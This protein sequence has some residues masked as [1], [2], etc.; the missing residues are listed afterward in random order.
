[1]ADFKILKIRFRWAGNWASGIS[2]IKDDIVRYGGKV[3]VALKTHTSAV[4]F[5]TDLEDVD[6]QIPPQS[7][8][9]WE[10]ML[11]GYEWTEDWQTSTFYQVGDLA[12]KNGIIYIC[13]ESH[14]S[15]AAEIDFTDDLDDS[16]WIVYTSTDNWRNNWTI[17]TS[18]SVNDIVKYNG[19]IYRCVEAHVSAATTTTGLELDQT[20][21]ILISDTVYWRGDWA[22]AT[23]YRKND[24]VRYGGWVYVCNTHH[25]STG[26]TSLGLE[27]NLSFWT[28]VHQNIEYKGVWNS[29]DFR[30]KINDIV[31]YGAGLWICI[32]QHNS[33]TNFNESN[34]QVYFP[35]FE[36]ENEWNSST[37]YQRGDIVSYGGY[38]Y[39][40]KTNNTN[41]TPST[42]SDDWELLKTSYRI[43][44]EWDSVTSYKVGDV[45]R[46]GGMLYVAVADSLNQETTD[47]VYWELLISGERWVGKWE[48]VTPYLIGDIVTY[49]SSS[50][51]C[52][53]KHTS[54]SLDRPDLDITNTY[55]V[56]LI[57]GNTGNVLAEPGDIKTYTSGSIRL[58]IGNTGEVLK[59]VN[60]SVLWSGF[61]IV[62]NVYYVSVDGDDT[63]AGT[64]LAAPWRTI[65]YACQ[66]I[67]G[68]ATIFIKTGTYQEILPISVPAQVALVGDEL[69]GTTV[70]PAFGYET[71]NM[72]YV[73]NGSGMRNMSLRGLSGVLGPV[74]INGTKRPSAGAYVSLD[75][76]TGTLDSS[77]WITTRSPYIQNVTV[78]GDACV[79]MKIDGSLH[80]GGNR[81]IVAND[82]TQILSDGIGIW[83]I[84]GGLTEQVSVFSYYAH[85]GYLAESGGKIRATNGNSSYGTFGCVSEGVDLTET[86]ITGIVNNRYYEAQVSQVFTNGGEILA[87]EY[88]NAGTNY[89]S[90]T[91]AF[92]GAGI[93]AVALGD[94]TRDQSIFQARIYTPGDSSAAGGSN[95]LTI[96]NNAQSGNSVSITIA[97]SDQ[98]TA[99]NYLGMRII[100]TSGTGAGQYGTI[101]NYDSISKVVLVL[102]DSD[103][104]AGW[105]H[106]VPGTAIQTVLDTTTRYRIEPKV[107]FSFPG[108]QSFARTVPSG[109]WSNATWTGSAFVAVPQTGNSTIRS[110]NGIT[111]SAGGDLPSTDYFALGSGRFGLTTY[112]VAFRSGTSNLLA[113]STDSG[114]SWTSATAPASVT[115]RSVAYGNNRFVAI[116]FN[117]T[118]T[119]ISTNGISWVSGGAMPSAIPW[120]EAVYGNGVW[121]A[122]AFGNAAAYSIDNGAN[123][124]SATMPASVNW[125]SVSYG[126]GRFVAVANGTSTSA[127]SFDGINWIV[128]TMPASSQW[129]NVKYGQGVFLATAQSSNSVAYSNNGSQWRT[130]GDDSTQFLLPA[131]ATWSG[132]SFGNPN[133][134]GVWVLFQSAG[135]G[136]AATVVTGARAIGRASVASGRISKISLIEPGSGYTTSPTVTVF[137]PNKTSNV[138][139]RLRVGNG[140]LAQPSFS[141]RGTGYVTSSTTVVINGD[142]YAED[143]QLGKDLILSNLSLL[144]SP[145]ANLSITG[146]NDV[147]YR[148]VTVTYL[149]GSTGNYTASLRISPILDIEESPDHGVAVSI[150]EKYSQVR[151][152]NH[153]FLEI[154]TGNFQSSSYPNT[155]LQ[156]LAPENEVVEKG[157]GRVFYSSTDQEGNFRVGELF[158]VEQSTGIVTVSADVFS[159]SGLTE[160]SLGGVTVG[161]SEVVIREFSTDPTF[162]ADS[163]NIIPTQRAI[164]AYL[165]S[166]IAGGGA[167]AVATVAVAG[168]VVV[169][170]QSLSTTTGSAIQVIQKANFTRGIDGNMLQWQ[171]FAYSFKNSS[172]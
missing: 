19:I 89:T 154:G 138:A 58:P 98:N 105:D 139:V 87:L 142:G 118:S 59:S 34:W 62:S 119:A 168:T 50:Y 161:G 127:Y 65:R 166:R 163:N 16:Y 130:S 125:I 160:L 38:D 5:Y 44:G 132:L 101:Y 158:R 86:P 114:V 116:S 79:G 8:P 113:Y 152:T 48:P 135:G 28:I 122:V 61:N 149:S 64:S 72:F 88:D 146:I 90:A 120:T 150:R 33:T 143:Y 49:T 80:S 131:S 123:W 92:S 169:G 147:T 124:V 141:N 63:N 151:L 31:K 85:I 93:N 53:A 39:Y 57:E 153:D 29:T 27:N 6:A 102:R 15:V 91:Y 4:N 155:P 84:N 52:I 23:R 106:V 21:W 100:I 9:V 47:T 144:P 51:K 76:G 7:D 145:G 94:E 54:S 156:L 32:Q 71:S 126:N 167:N 95:Y 140:A 77:V 99:S 36:F 172:E 83:C 103:D 129:N 11:D 22:T 13:V 67:T 97:A 12:K 55:W 82:F 69:R 35:G 46:R 162:T 1:M 75:P 73:R 112:T 170:P 60:S 117:S 171:Y 66:S 104:Q 56:L 78:F 14:T 164:K 25:T 41:Q 136:N 2:Y 43:R 24:I 111:W 107:S 137:D 30:Y 45:V 26:S 20:K 18:Y 157:G 110:T 121:V 128:S 68:P 159:L 133:N 148:V 10:L 81:S 108:F 42:E 134:I 70:E 40:A 96:T 37:V 165:T 74:N 17:S 115:W 3:Y 109:T